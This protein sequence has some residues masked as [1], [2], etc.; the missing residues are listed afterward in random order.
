ML[1]GRRVPSSDRPP[2]FLTN[3]RGGGIGDFGFALGGHLAS[4][5]G[6]LR[7]EETAID[8]EGSFRQSWLAA[9]YSGKVIA[10]LGLTAWGTS[11]PRNFS[12][13]TSLGIHQALGLPTIVIVHHAIEIFD[14]LETGFAVRPLLRL[15]AHLAILSL[16]QC[17]LVVFSP[18]L[19][20]LLT[21]SYGARS[22]WLTPLPGERARFMP[23]P[24]SAGKPKVVSAGYWAPY[25]GIDIFLG[26]AER[27]GPAFDFY[28]VGKPHPILSHEP[29][30]RQRVERWEERANRLGVRQPG[31]LTADQ[32]DFEFKENT[33]GVLPYTSASGASASF[34]LFAERAIPVVASHLPEFQYLARS[35]AG[36]LTA[37]PTE[38]DLSRAVLR[39]SSDHALWLQLARMQAKFAQD[40]SWGP[41]IDGLL[42]EPVA[43]PSTLRATNE[44]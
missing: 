5:P 43:S 40:N 26:L 29:K 20:D 30:F 18:R 31:F 32:L 36:V 7:V 4:R 2:L 39:L 28:L 6:G 9:T 17:R 37:P 19:K 34:Q 21:G 1:R 42:E 10:N 24:R 25:K 23:T 14:P 22:V 11:G 8:G 12:G 16:S 27:L 15:G 44:P 38:D 35:G 3:Y 13:F 33:I 41:F